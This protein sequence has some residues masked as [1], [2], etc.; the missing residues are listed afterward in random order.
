[1]VLA[2]NTDLKNAQL[3]AEKIRA[4]IESQ[5]F[6]DTTGF[7]ISAGVTQFKDGDDTTSLLDRVDQALYKAKNEGRNTVRVV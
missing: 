4:D 5:H 2:L 3:I 6:S 7:T 1:M